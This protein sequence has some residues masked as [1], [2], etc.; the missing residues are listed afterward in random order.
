[1]RIEGKVVRGVGE[2]KEFLTIDWVNAQL[3]EKFRFQP[4]PGTLNITLRDP[5]VQRVLKEKGR[6][7]LTHEAEGFCDAILIKGVINRRYECGVVIPLVDGYDES[8]LEVVSAV[9]L[10]QTLHIDDGDVVTLDLDMEPC[11]CI[12]QKGDI[13]DKPR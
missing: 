8:L 6:A 11:P 2:S 12:M 7:R 13:D 10:K 4:F 5:H 9:H 1:M 3:C